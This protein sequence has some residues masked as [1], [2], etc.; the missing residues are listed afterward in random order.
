MKMPIYLCD[1]VS[2]SEIY[3]VKLTLKFLA[4]CTFVQLAVWQTSAQITDVTNITSTPIP[5]VGHDYLHDL[6]EIVNPANGSLSVRIAAPTP[7][8]RGMNFPIYAF[9]YDS[10]GQLTLNFRPLTIGCGSSSCSGTD[11]FGPTLAVPPAWPYYPGSVTSQSIA[12]TFNRG[13]D[14][15][16]ITCNYT[17]NYIYTDLQGGRHSLKLNTGLSNEQGDGCS[18]FGIS[19]MNYGGDSKYKAMYVASRLQLIDSHGDV[20]GGGI[21]GGED[22][23]GNYR[24]G[25]GRPWSTTYGTAS[26]RYSPVSMTVPGFSVPFT[27]QYVSV[28]ASSTGVN[29][30]FVSALSQGNCLGPETGHAGKSAELSKLTLP[31]GQYY[32]FGYDSVYG[33]LNSITYP[34]GARVVYVWGVNTQSEMTGYIDNNTIGITLDTKSECFYKYDWPAIQSRTVYFDGSTPA[35][36]QTFAYT[37]TWSGSGAPYGQWWSSKSTTV[38]TKDL[39]RPGQPSFQTIYTYVPSVSSPQDATSTAIPTEVPLE[40]QV[41]YKDS[42]GNVLRTI[43]KTWNGP[44]QISG[45]CTTLPNGQT[46]GTFYTY[47]SFS[48]PLGFGGLSTDQVTDLQEYDFGSVSVPCLNPGGTPARETKTTYASLGNTPYWPSGQ[49][50]SDRPSEVRVYDHGTLISDT[51]YSY[52]ETSVANVSPAPLG[53]D[54]PVYGASAASEPRGNVTTITRKC[55]STSGS[56]TDAVTKVAYD[57]TGQAVS[58]TDP[59]GN[60]T[61]L[62]YADNYTSDDGSPSGNTN[63]YLSKITRPTTNGV[64]HV[65][66]YEYDYQKGVLRVATDENGQSSRYSYND[67]W[68]RLTSASFPD[69]G[70]KGISYSDV[71]PKPSVTTSIVLNGSG[72]TMTATSTMDA[73]GHVIATTRSS[74]PYGADIVQSAYDGNGMLWTQTN[75]FRGTSPPANTSTTQYYDSLGRPTKIVAQDG[76][77]HQ[78]CFDDVLSS[79]QGNC[80]LQ[81]GVATTGS[82]ADGADERMNDWQKV[83]DAF[84]RITRVWEPSGTNTAPSMETDYLYDALGN[85]LSVQQKGMSGSTARSRVFTYDSLSRLTTAVNPETGTIAYTY[86]V[87]GNV[88]SKTSP[89]VNVSSG[90]QVIGYCYDALNRLTVKLN[91]AP[92]V[93]IC[94]SPATGQ[95]LESFTYDASSVSGAQFVV[96]RLTDEK[97]YVGSTLVSERQLFAYD[98]MGRLLQEMRFIYPSLSSGK[99]LTYAYDYAGNVT[100]LTNPSGAGN[101]PMI[102]KYQYD[103]ESR[104]SSVMADT[105]DNTAAPW[106][107][108]PPNLFTISGTNGYWPDGTPWNWCLGVGSC[109]TTSP[110]S[111]TQ[112]IDNR[113][114]ITN[115]TGT[116]E[117][118]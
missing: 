44:D 112:T 66:I 63:T 40:A 16:M 60:V 65:S 103:S 36:I 8:E 95:V 82:W 30:T 49:Y 10:D 22:T 97:S 62:S 85:L 102:L 46:S 50:M 11:V 81:A 19:T 79:G 55:F 116:G 100:N 7:H 76:N 69:M 68:N 90:T 110:L 27:Y 12:L 48:W 72:A 33:L 77:V 108:L 87:N 25:T 96:G 61:S 56:C 111:V 18:H 23:N 4:L 57:E 41:V 47:G 43:T 114:R 115:I 13:P 17:G 29:S 6:N 52:D 2:A 71:G 28:P 15:Q 9:T 106:P 94:A 99:L 5:G 80:Y 117:V 70:S 113:L 53:H 42:S 21:T 64:A 93:A 78:V 89:A 84:G 14:N 32:S 1:R 35:Q 91:V 75:P 26:L 86:D 105:S 39:L 107:S 58:V 3:R 37:T 104:L 73:I 101:K 88:T 54:E 74:D 92:T 109:S 31:N 59:M 45:E 24:N 51:T 67:P 98:S 118:H 83:S 34:T 20:L 38:T